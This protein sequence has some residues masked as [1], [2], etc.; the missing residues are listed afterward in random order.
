MSTSEVLKRIADASLRLEAGMAGFLY[1]LI[2]ITA[3]SGATTATMGKLI[4]TLTSDTGVALIL[5]HL[6]QPVSKRPLYLLRSSDSSLWSL[7][8]STR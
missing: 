4:I 2:F 7:W 5:Y 1:L 6:L 3:P 8:P